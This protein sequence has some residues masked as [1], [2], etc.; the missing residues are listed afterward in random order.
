MTPHL[1][2]LARVATDHQA[3]DRQLDA[4]RAAG[5]E[6]DRIVIEYGVSG[7]A[8]Q[9][10]GLDELLLRER[11][12][13]A[14]LVAELS[15]LA[16]RA[17]KVLSLLRELNDRGVTV[18]CLQPALIF[19]GSPMATLLVTLLSAVA[20]MERDAPLRAGLKLRSKRES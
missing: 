6:P 5:V 8:K 4:L 13:D 7:D 12:G 1:F 3:L 14:V 9:R 2:G 11:D 17:V 10:F 16:R 19:D 15:R 20:E 18:R